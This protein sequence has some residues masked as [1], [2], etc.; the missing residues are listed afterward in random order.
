MSNYRL[1]RQ[2]DRDLDGI[3]D[4]IADFNPTAALDVLDT[5]H[6]TFAFLAKNPEAGTLREDLRPRLRIFSPGRPAHNYVI[7]FHPRADGIEVISVIHGAQ[8]W[9]A[10]FRR[11]ER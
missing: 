5:L 2:A 11:G 1:S 6:D 3:A 7:F 4:H 8:D 10:M 9:T